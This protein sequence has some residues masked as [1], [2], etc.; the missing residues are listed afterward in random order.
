MFI[1]GISHKVP[2]KKA[3]NNSIIKEILEKN[4]GK[5]SGEEREDLTSILNNYF[6]SVGIES[7]FH[8]QS[9]QYS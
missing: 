7:R 9:G 4:N 6:D 2:S 8:P 5:L 1:S 3:D